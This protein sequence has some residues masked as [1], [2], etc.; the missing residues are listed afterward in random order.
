M[1]MPIE[2]GSIGSVIREARQESGILIEEL[3]RESGISKSLL[4]KI[5]SGEYKSTP[6][7]NILA[8]IPLIGDFGL[9]DYLIR[10]LETEIRR[11]KEL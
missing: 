4:M 11:I 10:M 8:L 1:R 7:A 6:Y 5:E 2:V 9:R 3:V